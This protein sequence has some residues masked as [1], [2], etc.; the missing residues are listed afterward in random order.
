MRRSSC[1]L[2]IQEG[3]VSNMIG[4][5]GI[6]GQ[7]LAQKTIALVLFLISDSEEKKTKERNKKKY[8]LS[9]RLGAEKL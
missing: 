1:L 8:V 9:S 6:G 7:K 3:N 4:A 2:H 5:G